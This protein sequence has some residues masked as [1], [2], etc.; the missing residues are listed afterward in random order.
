MATADSEERYDDLDGSPAHHTVD[1]SFRGRAYEIDLS[2][3]HAEEFFLAIEKYVDAARP[4]EYLAPHEPPRPP[5][6]SEIR[7]W[8]AKVGLGVPGTGR[9]AHSVRVAYDEAHRPR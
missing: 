9:I 4:V 5:T 8:A 6:P 3:D 2:T 7:E 1:F